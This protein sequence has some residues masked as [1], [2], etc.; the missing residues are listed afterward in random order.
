MEVGL[1]HIGTNV[2]MG[3]ENTRKLW[4]LMDEFTGFV[5]NCVVNFSYMT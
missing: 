3:V 5:I 1:S 2:V 4:S